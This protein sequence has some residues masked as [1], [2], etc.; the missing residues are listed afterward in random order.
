MNV[1]ETIYRFAVGVLAAL[2]N[3]LNA[4]A[5]AV[6]ATATVALVLLT[7]WYVRLTRDLAK[8]AEES[9]RVAREEAEGA[10]RNDAE[11]LEALCVTLMVRLEE[12]EGHTALANLEKPRVGS[13]G[14]SNGSI[15]SRRPCR[16]APCAR[17]LRLSAS[18]G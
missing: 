12:I 9:A 3:G 14:N 8:S 17:H 6:S 1:I 18:F 2:V 10:R 16:A 15:A 7:W 4:N 5:G 13:S 11:A